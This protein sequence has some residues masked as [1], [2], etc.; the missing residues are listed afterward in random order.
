[1][2]KEDY[3]YHVYNRA[4][5]SENLFREPNNYRYFLKKYAQHVS[6]VT[7]TFVYCLLLNHFHTMVRVRTQQEINSMPVKPKAYDNW[8]QL[9]KTDYGLFVSKQFS[10][11][12]NSFTQSYNKVYN[13][14][15]SLF[16]PNMKKKE[17]TSDSYYTDL[18]L[19]F[20]DN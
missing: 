3:T 9:G 5:G 16:Q 18:I 11:F 10:N 15:G 12:F 20:D 2:L 6:P 7:E 8:R 19:E 1:M 13:R 4:N 17:V 14:T